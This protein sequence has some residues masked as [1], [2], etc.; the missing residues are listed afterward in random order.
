MFVAVPE[1][2]R[3]AFTHLLGDLPGIVEAPATVYGA[4]L[5]SAG[6][7]WNISTSEI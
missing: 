5:G 3:A 1:S 7:Q 6:S 2:D 4:V